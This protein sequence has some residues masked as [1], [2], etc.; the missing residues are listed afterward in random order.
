[1]NKS[2]Q[3]PGSKTQRSALPPRG[4]MLSLSVQVPLILW[5]WPLKPAAVSVLAGVTV[6]VAGVVLNV[7]AERLFRKNG[8][9]VCPFSPV[10]RLISTGPYRFT[11][12]PMY[13]GMVLLSG[14]VSLMTGL[15]FNL[16]A[17]ALLAIWLHFRFVLPEEDFLR[18]RLGVE[19][20]VYASANSRW[21][22]LPG[23]HL[24]SMSA[25]ASQSPELARTERCPSARVV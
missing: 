16:V 22:G 11:R 3:T 9:G 19:Y 8:V 7:W 23:P 5:S 18:G 21:L 24:A 12:N 4:L 25:G 13:L 2:E 15:Y 14:G 20:L 17:S 10:S 1:M 6:L